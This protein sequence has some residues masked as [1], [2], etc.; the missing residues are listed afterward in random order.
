MTRRTDSLCRPWSAAACMWVAFAFAL[1]AYGQ[2]PRTYVLAPADVISVTVYNQPQLTG[3]YVVEAD[4]L[5]TFPLLGRLTIGGLTLRAVEDQLR[6]RLAKGYLNN[7]Q[8]T[9]A[10][11]AYRNQQV[12]VMG[13]VRQPGAFQ[14]SAPITLIEALAR[15]GSTT[16]RAGPE[17]MIVRSA[18]TGTPPDA[19][20]LATA[21]EGGDAEVIRVD[22]G[23]LQSGSLKQ[24]VV[25]FPGDTLFVPRAA[26]VIVSG[27]V[28][29]A[30]EY[31]LSRP[32]TVRQVI[33]LAGGVTERGSMRRIQILRVVNGE[34]V[35]L[36]ANLKD[37][38]Q[39]GDTIV[40]RERLF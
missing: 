33:A 35:T 12:F 18:R 17:A 6:E 27:Q 29:A 31:V 32:M 40:V 23:S 9:V 36:S 22:L 13:E 4:G 5:I 37:M 39:P 26:P 14:L 15:A 19:A 28:K 1:P 10:I 21:S 2:E 25:L 38:V 34:E 30:G 8:V 7:P 16:D 3:K 24:N 20:A 11:A